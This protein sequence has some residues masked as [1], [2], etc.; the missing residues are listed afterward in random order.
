MIE[1][2][3]KKIGGFR[4]VGILGGGNQGMVYSAISETDEFS[5]CPPGTKVA[6]KTMPAKDDGGAFFASLKQRT[7]ELAL[8]A[9]RNVVRYYGCFMIQEAFAELHVVVMEQLS[10][11]T[12]KSRLARERGG[13]DA[14]VA[15][16]IANGIVNGLAA[17]AEKGI[18]HRDVKPGNV[19][20]CHDGAVK[21]I[22]F[23]VAK[24]DD[25]SVTPSSGRM[26]GS[27]DYMAPDFTDISFA[28]DVQSDIFSA[29][30]VIHEML[31]G[32][33]PYRKAGANR[34]QT[35]A[36]FDFLARWTR[37]EYGSYPVTTIAVSP[38][39]RR[40]LAHSEEFFS[41][42]LAPE[43]KNRFANYGQMRSSLVAVRFRDLRVENR[44]Y[45]ILQYVGKGGFGEVFKARLRTT[46]ELVAV[47]HLLNSDYTD[48]FY[49]E[50]K[51]MSQLRDSC[52]VRFLDFMVMGHSSNRSAFIIMS[53]LPGM[54]GNSLKD[55]I[56]NTPGGL[57]A[58]DVLT[59][60]VR[61]AHGLAVMHSRGIFHRDIKP[62]NLYFPQGHPEDSAI[63]DLGIARD[64]NGTVTTGNVP[65]TFDYM[66]PEVVTAKNRG[67][68]G[69]DI[70]ALGLCLFEALTG[71]TAYP[72]LPRGSAAYAMFF[73]R[74][75]TLERPA[76]DSSVV[77]SDSRLLALIT[78]MTEPDFSRRLC[79]AVEVE[80]RLR[81]LAGG[82][83]EKTV[84]DTIDPIPPGAAVPETGKSR[85]ARIRKLKAA[86]L[87]V[88]VSAVCLIMAVAWRYCP[89]ERAF[90]AHAVQNGLERGIEWIKA[91]LNFRP[92]S[93]AILKGDVNE[94]V[95]AAVANDVESVVKSDKE[96]S[97]SRMESARKEDVRERVMP[98]PVTTPEGRDIICRSRILCECME[99]VEFRNN[100]IDDAARIVENGVLKQIISP[101]DAEKARDHI[102]MAKKITVFRIVNKS[103]LEISVGDVGLPGGEKRVFAFT[104]SVPEGLAVSC[105]GYDSMPLGVQHDGQTIYITPE[106]LA[107]AQ[108][109]VVVPVLNA[110]VRCLIDGS[111]VKS[112][113]VRLKPGIHQC[114]Y[115]RKGC[116][117]QSFSFFV[118]IAKPLKLPCPMAWA[119]GK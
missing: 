10:G 105:N 25:G 115:E 83:C 70:Y 69:M 73:K 36:D 48:R 16:H 72:R 63:M 31:V 44:T 113:S 21:L 62:S 12:L 23:E 68:S 51:I 24:L 86:L 59:A 98:M 58:D 8:I 11:E 81:L 89:E 94:L 29:G 45:R 35:K 26:I 46:G 75:Q 61:Y 103:D 38:R 82:D 102:A 2:E 100:R 117:T 28:G 65:G 79:S 13:L 55:A 27:Y 42:S 77:A 92:E 112:G 95:P 22:D 47:K 119:V 111:V 30:V 67:E 78:E 71:T 18:C 3:G 52:F 17:A 106:S 91:N 20:I 80:R 39:I 9:H 96:S 15:V 40:L 4:I 6:L 50:A 5:E 60:F 7:S 107:P 88:A 33:L 34:T 54:P 85:F 76:I 19:F 41:G 109:E 108:V 57:P 1:L 53:F 84:D 97:S 74:A 49:R 56:R 101:E 64:V 14:D 104:N 90:V 93:S 118:E 116:V 114:E 32:A 110:G 87:A 66:P 37:D 99:P 43:R